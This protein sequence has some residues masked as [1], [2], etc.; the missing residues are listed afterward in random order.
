MTPVLFSAPTLFITDLRKALDVFG[1]MPI[2]S[3]ICLVLRSWSRRSTISLSRRV[4]RNFRATLPRLSTPSQFLSSRTA[5]ARNGKKVM[6]FLESGRYVAVVA[7]GKVHL[8]G[9]KN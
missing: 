5:M 1:L 9:P 2:R 3:A 7:D 6:Q 8:Y 4:R